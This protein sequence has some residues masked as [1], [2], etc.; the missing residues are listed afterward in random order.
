MEKENSENEKLCP[1]LEY[2]RYLYEVDDLTGKSTYWKECVREKCPWYYG[3]SK[4]VM[5]F[6]RRT[7]GDG[8]WM[9]NL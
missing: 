4:E 1:Y 6:C 5:S 2:E 8:K 3:T 7:W 9:T